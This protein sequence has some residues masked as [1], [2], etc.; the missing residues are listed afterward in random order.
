MKKLMLRYLCVGPKNTPHYEEHTH[1]Q[2]TQKQEGS[3]EET[4]ADAKRK[5][6]GE[7]VQEGRQTR[8]LCLG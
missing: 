7:A 6:G 2:R 5:E 1:A 8:D 3:E 4:D